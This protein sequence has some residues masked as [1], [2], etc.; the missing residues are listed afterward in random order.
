M[1][2][3]TPQR[4]EE[5]KPIGA[6]R[7]ARR[8]SVR[9]C[10]CI[11]PLR[12]QNVRGSFG[13]RRAGA[14]RFFLRSRQAAPEERRALRCARHSAGR[15]PPRR[16]PRGMPAAAPRQGTVRMG[17]VSARRRAFAPPSENVP[18]P[19]AV[20][21]SISPLPNVKASG[22][23]S[24]ALRGQRNG[25]SRRRAA[26]PYRAPAPRIHRK[27]EYRAGSDARTPSARLLRRYAPPAP[28]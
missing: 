4:A 16:A 12:V 9:R 27:P 2:C 18:P 17:P 13:A 14:S 23:R 28:P 5:R 6:K 8:N 10:A 11:Q 26:A 15:A 1:F 19:A 3:A 24:R 21:R 7:C 25:M 20:R 22:A